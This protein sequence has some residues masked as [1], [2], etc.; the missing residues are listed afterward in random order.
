MGKSLPNLYWIFY[1]NSAYITNK[2]NKQNWLWQVTKMN[3]KPSEKKST[4]YVHSTFRAHLE[5]FDIQGDEKPSD[6]I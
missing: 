4:I 1:Y 3:S 5:I 2:E 6:E